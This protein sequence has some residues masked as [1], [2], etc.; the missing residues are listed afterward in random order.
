MSFN[1]RNFMGVRDSYT[2]NIHDTDPTAQAR[3]IIN[4]LVDWRTF[5]EQMQNRMDS[6][7]NGY[8]VFYDNPTEKKDRTIIRG[9]LLFQKKQPGGT[10]TSSIYTN[11][12]T[13]SL[14]DDGKPFVMA[15]LNS[16]GFFD[17]HNRVFELLKSGDLSPES[18]TQFITSHFQII[19]ISNAYWNYDQGGLQDE[20]KMDGFT[21]QTSGIAFGFAGYR[22]I[23]AGKMVVARAPRPDKLKSYY[24]MV[25]RKY[26]ENR[27]DQAVFMSLEPYD[28]DMEFNIELLHKRHRHKFP[29]CIGYEFSNEFDYLP[30]AYDIFDY[31]MSM[32]GY[33][34]ALYSTIYTSLALYDSLADIYDVDEVEPSWA[35]PIN[36]LHVQK[37]LLETQKKVYRGT[38]RS[39]IS[40]RDKLLNKRLH[41]ATLTVLDSV[42]F[43]LHT[44]TYTCNAA[45][46]DQAFK[47][48]NDIGQAS[49]AL[50]TIH[51]N[52]LRN[53]EESIIGIALSSAS[54]G[55][56]FDIQLGLGRQVA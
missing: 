46:V 52:M 5:D 11:P 41:M 33:H 22:G 39:Y 36:G 8:K 53:L 49:S 50:F 44:G 21:V 10:G 1:D 24:P 18:Y 14:G 2:G 34:R 6:N 37:A 38:S 16:S 4:A 28:P 47:L 43:P 13:G 31:D 9:D 35:G 19:G 23:T 55:G 26:A 12:V 3:V 27:S 30:V 40:E 45:G 48:R 15:T 32:E 25:N 7:R 29:T 17:P 51:H 54:P 42:Y 20:N 56:R